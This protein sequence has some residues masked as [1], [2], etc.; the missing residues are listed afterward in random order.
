[1]RDRM[2]AAVAANRG[3]AP[4]SFVDKLLGFLFAVPGLA[5]VIVGLVRFLAQKGLTR[6]DAVV[7]LGGGVVCDLAGLAAG[8]YM[9]GIDCCYFPT[10]LLAMVDAAL[11][12]KTAI[13][14]DGVKNAVGLFRQPRA[15]VID[16]DTLATLPPRQLANGL[17]EAVKMALTSDAALFRL[18]EEIPHSVRT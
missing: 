16:P 8:L 7:A 1:V 14:L 12:G 5:T 17:A 18:L 2:E 6:S 9:R 11:G 3:D 10:S 13:D 4:P 15:V